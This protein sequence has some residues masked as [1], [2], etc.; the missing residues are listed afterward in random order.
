MLPLTDYDGDGID[1]VA[2]YI[3]ASG[4]LNE[5]LSNGG[6]FDRSFTDRIGGPAGHS[7]RPTSMATARPTRLFIRRRYGW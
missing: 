2:V 3:E 7:S 4:T 5:M 1:D 6:A